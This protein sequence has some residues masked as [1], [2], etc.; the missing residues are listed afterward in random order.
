MEKRRHSAFSA[1]VPPAAWGA[2]LARNTPSTLP[3]AHLSM[4][5]ARQQLARASSA[6]EALAA[7]ASAVAASAVAAAA[8]AADPQGAA[9]AA[10]VQAPLLATPLRPSITPRTPPLRSLL[11]APPPA[12]CWPLIETLNKS[13]ASLQL[14]TALGA[15]LARRGGS[16]EL[17]HTVGRIELHACRQPDYIATATTAPPSLKKRSAPSSSYRGVSYHAKTKRWEAHVW[18]ERAQ[19][20]LGG[21]D[22]EL[23]AARAFDLA[24]LA[25]KGGRARTNFGEAAYAAPQLGA[26]RELAASEGGTAKLVR[27]MRRSC[28][29]FASGASRYRGVT[30]HAHKRHRFE[31]RLSACRGKGGGP[32]ASYVYL[33]CFHDEAE[34]ARAYDRAA[35]DARGDKAITNFPRSDYLCDN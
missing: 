27:E 17:L 24:S 9:A 3:Y 4:P 21:H 31:A 23:E 26:L 7:A 30:V 12:A 34:A 6:P 22:T 20:Y 14:A 5:A 19:R 32:R 13:E 2:A 11:L 8:A 35:I 16:K 25:L 15:L 33:G 1:Y 10:A 28:A 29:T 18:H